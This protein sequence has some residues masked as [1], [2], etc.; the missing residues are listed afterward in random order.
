MVFDD[1][2][3]LT[4]LLFK[5][6]QIGMDDV[7]LER[8]KY[9]RLISE[10]DESADNYL[11]LELCHLRLGALDEVIRVLEYGLCDDMIK[12]YQKV[13]FYEAL[14][15]R[16]ALKTGSVENKYSEL[17]SEVIQE[18]RKPEERITEQTPVILPVVNCSGVEDLERAYKVPLGDINQLNHKIYVL[19]RTLLDYWNPDN[20]ELDVQRII[21]RLQEQLEEARQGKDQELID[22]IVKDIKILKEKFNLKERK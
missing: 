4:Q 12:D 9:S 18:I 11:F 7:R 10:G 22:G 2:E 8:R 1:L 17:L 16:L 5:K 21:K 15:L 14:F 20:S 6:H 3:Y 19:N 13:N